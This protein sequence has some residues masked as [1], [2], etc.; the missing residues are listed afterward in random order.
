MKTTD[1][2]GVMEAQ[3]KHESPAAVQVRLGFDRVSGQS[4]RQTWTG[5]TSSQ[6]N[7]RI[8]SGRS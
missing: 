4:T 1:I 5:W 8:V 3:K 7:G 2:A 6:P